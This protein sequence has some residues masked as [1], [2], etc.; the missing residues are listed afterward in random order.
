V[1]V[2]V[3]RL[4]KPHVLR[5][6]Q[7]ESSQLRSTKKRGEWCRCQL[8]EVQLIRKIRDSLY[9]QGFTIVGARNKFQASANGASHGHFVGEPFQK[10]FALM[11]KAER[12]TSLAPASFKNPNALDRR[13]VEKSGGPISCLSQPSLHQAHSELLDI[14]NLCSSQ[15][16]ENAMHRVIISR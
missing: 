12:D 5:Y 2:A 15:P 11:A 1:K 9:E 10:E 3:C 7:Q 8:H 16:P 13:S 4:A 14:R 6:W